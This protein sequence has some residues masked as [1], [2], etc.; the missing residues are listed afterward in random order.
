VAAP[1]RGSRLERRAA[2]PAGD[3]ARLLDDIGAGYGGVAVVLAGHSR[4]ARAAFGA[5]GNPAVCAVAGLA[6]WLPPGERVDQL[7]G[8]RVLLAHGSADSVTRPGDPWA[9]VRRARAVTPVTAL[10]VRGGGHAM[11]RR[12]GLWHA[13]AAGF[14]RL[15]SGLPAG[16]G[17]AAAAVRAAGSG[18]AG[19][20]T[21]V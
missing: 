10:G 6:P 18:D 20:I 15:S 13:I 21:R 9:Y 11:M 16:P 19:W 3:L 1:V 2:W 4:G 7:A 17:P 8:R 12:A 14:A 5:A